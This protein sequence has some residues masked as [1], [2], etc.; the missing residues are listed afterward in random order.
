MEDVDAMTDVALVRNCEELRVILGELVMTGVAITGVELEGAVNELVTMVVEVKATCVE[1]M[2]IDVELITTGI[3]V[4]TD[5]ELVTID[6]EDELVVRLD[7]LVPAG[8]KLVNIL[9]ELGTTGIEL[10]TKDIESVK[11]LDDVPIAGEEL[12]AIEIEF[13]TKVDE[14]VIDGVEIAPNEVEL[15]TMA[16]EL[17]NVSEELMTGDVL[18]CSMTELVDIIVELDIVGVEPAVTEEIVIPVDELNCDGVTLDTIG[19]E[20]VTKVEKCVTTEVEPTSICDELEGDRVELT[21]VGIEIVATLDELIVVVAADVL[22]NNCVES[23][24][25]SP[26]VEL[27]IIKDELAVGIELIISGKD[28]VA[29]SDIF[30]TEA[31]ELDNARTE[32]VLITDESIEVVGEMLVTGGVAL[33]KPDEYEA[34]ELA[35]IV[36]EPV[37]DELDVELVMTVEE[38]LITDDETAIMV[39]LAGVDE[40]VVEELVETGVELIDK[41]PELVSNDIADVGD[42]CNEL[43]P[44]VVE[45]MRGL[46]VVG[47]ELMRGLLVVG[48]ELM[49]GLLVVGI[50]LDI[51]AEVETPDGKL[52]VT[53]DDDPSE[54]VGAM[55]V[56][57]ADV[58]LAKTVEFTI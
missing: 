23:E 26:A 49:R 50:E 46:L 12:A 37:V 40:I 41:D 15:V 27:A 56:G 47:M 57:T 43:Y 54:D 21:L 42:N 9:L 32:L 29:R 6:V 31:E 8:V 58:E 36:V 55:E 11:E 4:S 53:A 48:M 38:L 1:L 39:D 34:T 2:V 44:N 25:C 45:L 14:L 35:C 19:V 33:V 30:V 24:L 28:V 5:T 17:I 13:V 3:D 16:V 52:N 10:V 22:D 18:I 20:L 51:R 7:E